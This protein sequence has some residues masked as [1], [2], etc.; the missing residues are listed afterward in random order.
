MIVSIISLLPH[1]WRAL[2]GAWNGGMLRM[3][4]FGTRPCG[5]RLLHIG[6]STA[7]QSAVAAMPAAT[8][9]WPAA[10]HTALRRTLQAYLETR[11]GARAMLV[12]VLVLQNRLPAPLSD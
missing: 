10:A 9:R 1:H 5:V 12:L 6:C 7:C 11:G 3:Q 4:R 2:M 8:H